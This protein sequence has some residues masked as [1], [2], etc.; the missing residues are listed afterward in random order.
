[1]ANLTQDQIQP[2]YRRTEYKIYTVPP[3]TVTGVDFTGALY[4]RDNNEETKV[5]ICL[6]TCANTRAVHLEVVSDLSTDT[7]LLSFRR[8][9]SCKSLPR[10]MMSDNASTYTSAAEEL[11]ALLQSEDL[12]TAMG[13]HSVVWKFIPKKAPWFGGF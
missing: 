10:V 9:A 7:F 5:Y 11:S 8:F 12:A 6:F 3:F 1:M 2:H 4:A 13:T